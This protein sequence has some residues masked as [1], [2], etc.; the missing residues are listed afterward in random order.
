VAPLRQLVETYLRAAGFEVSAGQRD[1]VIG[2][3]EGLGQ[4]TE[5]FLVWIPEV[6]RTGFV[7]SLEGPYLARFQSAIEQYRPT[8]HFMLVPSM[9][10]FRRE[11]LSSAKTIYG[12]EVRVPSDFFDQP[13][14]FEQSRRPAI[15]AIHSLRDRGE[16][17]LP[18]RIAQPYRLRGA[19]QE[20]ED[21]LADL[22]SEITRP[23]DERGPKIHVIVG[24]AGMGKSVCFEA[25]FARLYDTFQDL[26]ARHRIAARPLAL[27][28]EHLMRAD[29]SSFRAAL[30]SLLASEFSRTVEQEL[31]EWML[32]NGTALLMVDG[33]DE[34]VARDTAL[35]EDLLDLITK[36]GASAPLTVVLSV[37]DSLLATRSELRS[38]IDEYPSLVTVYELCSWKPDS[39]ARFARLEQPQMAD[40]FLGLL[41]RNTELRDLASLPFYSHCIL[42]NFSAGRITDATTETQL[43]ELV[44]ESMLDREYS[45]Q[46]ALLDEAVVKRAD[47]LDYLEAVAASDWENQERGVS[48]VDLEV[49]AR[50][51]LPEEDDV[52]PF[53]TN[54]TQVAF[55]RATTSA[56]AVT[57]AHDIIEEYFV[58][59]HVIRLLDRHGSVGAL[60]RPLTTRVLA[61]ESVALRIIADHVRALAMDEQLLRIAETTFTDSSVGYKNLVQIVARAARDERRLCGAS[62]DRRDLSGVHFSGLELSDCSFRDADLTGAEFRRCTLKSAAFESAVLNGTR[63][64]DL[65]ADALQGAEF[66]ELSSVYSITVERGRMLNDRAAIAK[67]LAGH[68]GR[69]PSVM[70]ACPAAQQVRLVFG[71]FVEEHGEARRKQL[72][73]RAVLAGARHFNPSRVLDS[74]T[75]HGF[76]FR[77][78]YR[79]SVRRCDGP[80][81]SD[82]VQF[83]KSLMV[84]TSVRQVLDEICDLPACSHVFS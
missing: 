50:V 19:D 40:A 43:L 24:P 38:F 29:T 84:A 72:G 12:V 20:A 81:Y 65:P 69:N 10:G 54:L 25:L 41:S 34:I 46:K 73:R 3:R 58:A 28:P 16:E 71:K 79:D 63:F 1:L 68:T 21:L 17:L 18:R 64:V 26:K 70:E 7:Q 67:W 48:V 39:V 33:L 31:F 56:E 51:Q 4:A 74:L 76:L 14:S 45:P 61:P 82:M 60:L 53:V 35:Y 47:V 13:F 55:F 83:R 22:L 62:F 77:P 32:L 9:E 6:S 23:A 8:H 5:T 30:R 37:R 59:R 57:F 11:F 27:I 52:E 42:D 66:G 75:T 2:Q 49:L 15:S 78:D 44:T 36:P 80:L